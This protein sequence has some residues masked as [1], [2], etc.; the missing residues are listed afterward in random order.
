M[1]R[2][3]ITLLLKEILADTPVLLLNGARQTGK[4]T[5]VQQL[6]RERPETQYISLDEAEPLAAA[7]RDP[8]G[9]IAQ[10]NQPVIID[11]VQRAPEIFM[12]IKVAVDKERHAGKFLLT[13]SANVLMLPKLADSLAGRMEIATLW[14]LS[15]GEL[16]GVREDFI[17]AVFAPEFSVRQY[18]PLPREELLS[19][20]LLGGYPPALERTAA[21]ARARWFAA[22]RTTLL[23]RDVR[24]LSMVRGLTDFPRLFT[25]LATRVSSLLNLA[26]LSRSTTI[27]QDTLKRY[28]AL[29]QALFLIVE[30][31]AWSANLGKRLAKTP[32]LA[33]NDTGLLSDLLAMDWRRLNGD[34]LALGRMLENFV[35]ME[36]RKQLTWSAMRAQLFH[37]RDLKDHEVDIVLENR[38]GELVG[39]EVKATAS[40]GP[41]DF[42][43]LNR[44]REAAGQR[45]L[46]GVLLH[47]GTTATHFMNGLYALPLPALWQH[48]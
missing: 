45:F 17:S 19:K 31:P 35:V 40:P 6:A 48:G 32:K 9:F 1:Y 27:Q 13:G 8:A 37:F 22:Y 46:R 23:E 15:Q 30:V 28:Y 18:S 11:E 39:I 10:F 20:M 34:P 25:A 24:D 14:P 12:P 36:L 41:G 7:K 29:L 47:G 42:S 44:L 43:G 3:N 16:A 4:T 33:L 5:L 38:A 26:D 21:T 2:R